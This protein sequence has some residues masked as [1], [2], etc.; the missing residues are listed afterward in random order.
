MDKI[1][2][3]KDLV[4]IKSYPEDGV[5]AIEA[6]IEN[7]LYN[8]CVKNFPE[9]EIEKQ[10]VGDGR[11]NLYIRPNDSK[12]K[13]LFIGH[14]DTVS[15]GVGW[16]KNILGE[17]EEDKFYGR[18]S[19]DMKSGLVAI[20]SAMH[21]AYESS[22]KETGFLF[23]CDE[24]FNFLGM[25]K[26]ITEMSNTDF[27]PEVVVAA[28]FTSELVRNGCRGL[29]EFSVLVKGKRG[30]ASRPYEG[31][32]AFEAFSTGVEK[33]KKLI[34]NVE[35]EDLG[36]ATLNVAGVY[37]GVQ[38]G[39]DLKTYG[40]VIPD[41]CFGTLEVRLVPGIDS[42]RITKTFT[43]GVEG[44]GAKLQE[45]EVIHD[46]KPYYTSKDKIK[47]I[48]E[49]HNEVFNT[50]VYGD[51]SKGGY[52]DI[53]MIAE[54]FGSGAVFWGPS[55]ENAHGIDECVDLNSLERVSDAFQ[56]LVDKYL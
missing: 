13:L 6:N 38:E 1:Q 16:T 55:G 30:H 32:N 37:C 47:V 24:E 39:E 15:P 49:I 3:L 26:F 46:L 22:K 53:Q 27:K 31:V 41:T 48:E 28:E 52:S 14:M 7:Y 25:K 35:H 10:K 17:L 42:E 40:N 34:E 23:Y 50:D 56:R 21:E 44:F 51:I 9:W 12:I 33:V 8:Y 2:I 43:N 54:A 11:N 5:S 29:L 20:I 19:L 36:S 45:C 4:A 18:G